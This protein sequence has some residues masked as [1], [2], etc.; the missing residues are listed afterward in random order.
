MSA[1]QIA[2]DYV[3]AALDIPVSFSVP[4]CPLPDLRSITLYPP[5]KGKV[6][7]GEPYSLAFE[8]ESTANTISLGCLVGIIGPGKGDRDIFQILRP[9]AR[10]RFHWHVPSDL[11]QQDIRV[12]VYN[13]PWPT[14]LRV[15]TL[16]FD[17]MRTKPT[18]SKRAHE[19]DRRLSCIRAVIAFMKMRATTS[20]KSL[21][22]DV[23]SGWSVWEGQAK[24]PVH[25]W[26]DGL[27][28]K[29]KIDVEMA[30]IGVRYDPD[31]LCDLKDFSWSMFGRGMAKEGEIGMPTKHDS[32][33]AALKYLD[34][35]P[36]SVYGGE[37]HITL[38]RAE[39]TETCPT[40]GLLL[41]STLPFSSLAYLPVDQS[42]PVTSHGI[43][44]RRCY[45]TEL[46][47]A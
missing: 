40:C 33:D 5:I 26:S 47:L 6:Q 14:R 7:Y 27:E 42:P 39:T 9:L 38:R 23:V 41:A 36:P 10:E 35:I 31:I 43:T 34:Q 4:F 21:I 37:V 15:V 1:S 12:L 32:I 29:K 22:L 28:R 20:K 2:L 3:K 24:R 17:T 13:I 11:L 44:I 30:S 25:G 46:D 8:R 18:E 45:D 19:R 16:S